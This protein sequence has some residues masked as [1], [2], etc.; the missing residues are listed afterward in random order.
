MQDF[1]RCLGTGI[2][3]GII[4]IPEKMG[5][6][7]LKFVDLGSFKLVVNCFTLYEDLVIK[8]LTARKKKG[9][10]IMSFHHV[11]SPR[12][13][14]KRTGSVLS[15]KQM[16]SVQ[17]AS[18]DLA[19]DNIFPAHQEINSIAIAIHA[20]IVKGLLHLKDKHLLFES[21]LNNTQPFVYEEL[22]SPEIR[23][24]SAEI[25]QAQV[26][27]LLHDFYYKLK[28]EALIYL[29]FAELL[30]RNN[31]STYP[32]NIADAK[33]LYVMRDKILS[34]LSTPPDLTELTQFSGMSESK[35]KRMFKQIF[36]NS[37]YSYYQSFRMDE[38][39]YL[40]KNKKCSVSEAGY[41][42]GFSNL[43]HFTRLF[44]KHIGIKPKKFSSQ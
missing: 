4:S 21:I 38:A 17:V 30:K 42:L 13:N 28:A 15:Y 24:V 10:V 33:M 14:E 12:Q 34:D 25:I 23:K 8:R 20:N 18:N 41:R 32:I 9:I 3:N 5:K 35:M 11:L 6:G 29:L 19:F 26:P 22:I 2:E 31:T 7:Y 1:A 43:S 27:Q 39:A 16:P 37:I 36:G 44:E 40:I